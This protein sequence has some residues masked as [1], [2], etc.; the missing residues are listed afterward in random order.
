[1]LLPD[2]F[3]EVRT[4][5]PTIDRYPNC[6]G[7]S[8]E[9]E[10]GR[11]R[12]LSDAVAPAPTN[13]LAGRGFRLIRRV[14]AIDPQRAGDLLNRLLAYV[15]ELGVDLVAHMLAHGARHADAAR[16]GRRLQPCGDVHAVAEDVVAVDV[17]AVEDDVAQVY[18]ELHLDALGLVDARVAPRHCALHV[19]R[20]Y[21]VDR[22]RELD[23]SAVADGDRL[24]IDTSQRR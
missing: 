5:T 3:I 1:M 23:Q 7:I 11:N 10:S 6:S 22:A 17:V 21:S 12:T 20:V 16:F 9:S 8:T 19:D 14:D 15:L 24:L 2:P 13:A 18:A 4:A